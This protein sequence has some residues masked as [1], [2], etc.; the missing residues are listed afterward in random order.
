MKERRYR[1]VRYSR[2]WQILGTYLTKMANS[3]DKKTNSL[4][5]A[6]EGGDSVVV[7][8]D[9][10]DRLFILVFKR[11]DTPCLIRYV[12]GQMMDGRRMDQ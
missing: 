2:K 1:C 10:D 12:D 4:E 9:D 8:D 7:V 11:N 5:L 3:L 6:H